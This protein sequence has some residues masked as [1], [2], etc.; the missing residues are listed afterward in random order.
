MILTI[1]MKTTIMITIL[2]T[3]IMMI[4]VVIIHYKAIEIYGRIT[5]NG[6]I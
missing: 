6:I 1:I 3:T 2:I 4:I 5:V